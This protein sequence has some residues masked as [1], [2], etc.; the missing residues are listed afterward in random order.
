M[1]RLD[2][3]PTVV[4]ARRRPAPAAPGVIDAADLRRLCLEAGA[5]DVG[6]VAIDRPELDAERA[7]IRRVFPETRTL[8]CLVCRMNPDATRSPARSVANHEFHETGDAV[9]DAT[10]RIVAA[11]AGRGVRGVNPPMAFPMEMDRFPG[12]VWSL[13][14]KPLAEAAGLGRMGI[15]R[16]V[17]HPRFG[18][19]I[20]IGAV[21]IDAEVGEQ[22]APLDYNPCLSC[23]LCVA[24]CP[25]GAISPEGRFDFTACFTHNYREFMGGFTDWAETIAESGGAAGYRAR[26]TDAEGA[27]MW[28]SLAYGPNYKAA[29]CLA[30]CPA[31]ED[32]IAPFLADRGRFVERVVR[33]LQ[34]KEEPIYV[35]PNTDAEAYVA[36]RF[37]HKRVRRVGAVTRPGSVAGF[38]RL[39]RHSF[40]PGRAGDLDATYHFRFTGAERAECTV[41]IRG[42]EIDVAEGLHGRPDLRVT[43]DARSWVRLLRKEVSPL[44]LLA[45]L[46]VRLRGHPRLFAAFGRCFP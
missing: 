3:H 15:H 23:K 30:V 20:L 36:R 45:T 28:Q 32:V 24:A 44:R 9:N 7:D 38:I 40:Q 16:N 21:L 35:Q 33:P 6:F 5:D 22:S 39:M 18:N 1:A 25:V 8:V 13:S 12:K 19:F 37:P 10:R 2:E 11:L 14:L 46:R 29:Y 17:I 27:S 31:G 42:G 34:A 43:A 4:A 41:T 26:V